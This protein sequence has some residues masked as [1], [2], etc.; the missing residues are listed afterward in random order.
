MRPILCRVSPT[1]VPI[2][3]VA[4]RF[5]WH[6]PRRG[7][8]PRS[9]R[10][11]VR[12][13]WLA[14]A[15][16]AASLIAA[17]PN[18]A[19]ATAPAP[20]R[21]TTSSS[22]DAVSELR[23]IETTARRV[24]DRAAPAVVRITTR[25]RG[26]ATA[27]GVLI[28]PS[29][30]VLTAGHVV[31][32]RRVRFLVEW[33]TGEVHPAELLGSIFERDIDLA[34]LRVTPSD[35]EMNVPDEAPR[36]PHAPLAPEGSLDRGDWVLAI[37]HAAAISRAEVGE[38]AS[39]LGRVLAVDRATLAI[40]SPIDAGDSGGPI[41]DMDGQVVGI[42]SRCGAAAWQNLATSLDAI[43][44][45]LPHLKDDSNEPPSIDDWSGRVGRRTPAGSKRDPRILAELGDV[46]APAERRVVELR[47]GDRLIG[48]ATVVAP[49]RVVTK[50]SLF[51]R[52]TREPVVVQRRDGERTTTQALPLGIDS[53]LDLVLLEAPGVRL[54]EDLQTPIRDTPVD[55]GTVVIIPGEGGEAAA[56]GIVARD[57]D[58]LS[59]SDTPD[60]RPFLGVATRPSAEGGL[61]LTTVVPNSA[62][63]VAG[64]RG[65]D[66]LMTVDGRPLSMPSDLPDAL[67]LR[68]FGE[69]IRVGVVRD[70][71][72][73]DIEIPLGVRPDRSR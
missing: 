14:L 23:R 73:I 21:T 43:H 65:G 46:V 31:T 33:P 63:A 22:E 54:T 5:E 16:L 30:L 60:D 53:E 37:G 59:L 3:D 34:L 48:H 47:E 50:A 29:G 18:L 58:E 71:A 11:P 51:A 17:A 25:G 10:T 6:Q 9:L 45:W 19:T 44:A 13:G 72:M 24:I 36:W 66:R 61:S 40:D 28:D 62:A 57:R 4:S 39:R 49:D 38:P 12:P 70:N 64:L 2:R 7:D 52:H 15:T 32:G 41:I 1:E 8:G 56:F 27:S 55:S 67:A 26:S 42:A 20:I 68:T 35:D 69:P